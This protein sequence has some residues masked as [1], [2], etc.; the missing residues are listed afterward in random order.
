MTT[1]EEPEVKW[2]GVIGKSLAYICLHLADLKTESQD[3]KRDFLE[4]LGL[5]RRD[6]A[7]LLGIT[8][9]TLRVAEYKRKG[10]KGQT[11]VTKSR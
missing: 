11:R 2:L 6:I 7:G 1:L 3:K 10:R 4:M 5:S 9:E 8:E